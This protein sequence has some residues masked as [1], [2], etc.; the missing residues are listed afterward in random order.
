[1]YLKH[2]GFR[3]APF[4]VT[5]DPKFFYDSPRHR[6]AL[7]ALYYGITG[8]KGFAVITGEVGTGKTTLIRKV[9]RNLEANHHAVFIF[10]TLLTFDELL[11]NIMQELGLDA[12]GLSRVTLLSRLNEFLLDQLRN[13]HIVSLLID[14]AQNISEET[15]EAVRLLS[16]METDRE[17]L[18]QII[19]IGQPELDVKLN[20]RSLRQLKQRIALR[21]QL[22]RLAERN[23]GDYIRHRLDV[24]GYEGPDIFPKTAVAAIWE[25][26]CGTPRLINAIC[27]NALLTAFALSKK[28]VSADIIREVAHDLG[29]QAQADGSDFVVPDTAELERRQARNVARVVDL[30]KTGAEQRVRGTKSE[31]DRSRFARQ[32]AEEVALELGTT[33]NWRPGPEG[34]GSVVPDGRGDLKRWHAKSV[35]SVAELRGRKNQDKIR[36]VERE[37]EFPMPAPVSMREQAASEQ[38]DI[39]PAGRDNTI[40]S[41]RF[42]D[43]MIAA[44]TD[45]MGPMARLVVREQ[46]ARMGETVNRFPRKRLPPLLD[47]ITREILNDGLRQQFQE[48]M[49]REIQGFKLI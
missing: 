20:T 41:P 34:G 36:V 37:E 32:T 8:R 40:I 31:A 35:A 39:S 17:K 13:G 44:L 28:T 33:H 16:N 22:D 46:I 4:N 24:A 6:E 27:D 38:S 15:L 19:L 48:R 12:S 14:E 21:F 49:E 30:G 29:L 2:F 18:L 1:M 3:E 5:P 26:T 42:L 45:A 23:V 43:T 25:Y 7:A 10:N 11:Q 47:V 9:L